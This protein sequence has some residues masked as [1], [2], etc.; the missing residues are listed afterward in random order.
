MPHQRHLNEALEEKANLV[1]AAAIA[2]SRGLRSHEAR[3]PKTPRG[4]GQRA[5]VLLKTSTEEHLVKG[6]VLHKM[7]SVVAC[8]WNRREAPLERN[9]IYMRNRDVRV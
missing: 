4:S 1:N 9:L 2:A 7:R 5:S 6:A 3:K 8:G